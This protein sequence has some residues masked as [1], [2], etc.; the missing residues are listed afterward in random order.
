MKK[1]LFAPKTLLLLLLVTQIL[2]ACGIY[3]F[4]DVSIPADVKTIRLHFIENKAR[5]V[6]P[7]LSP[8]LTNKLQDKIVGQTR[9][10]RT[11]SEDADWVVSGYVSEYNVV[12]SGISSQQ[13]STN[14][15]TVG[16]HILLKDNKTGKDSEFDVTKSFEFSANQTI[17]QAEAALGD[18]IVQ[19]LSDEI[20]NRLFTNW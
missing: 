12:T 14:R 13:A 8:R 19:G 15:L 20:F 9:L 2:T 18:Q 1:T 17:Q 4:K 11:D 6:N 3:T 7:A 10:T 16:A 5:Y